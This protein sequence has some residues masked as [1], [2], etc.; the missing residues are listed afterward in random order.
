MKINAIKMKNKQDIIISIG[1]KR[2]SQKNYERFRSY[3]YL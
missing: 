3:I 2:D 1:I